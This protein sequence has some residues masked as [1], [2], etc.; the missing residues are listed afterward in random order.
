MRRCA[1]GRRWPAGRPLPPGEP[2]EAVVGV[3]AP[4]ERLGE[5]GVAFV[6]PAG[7]SPPAP[8]EL[9]EWA[10]ARLANSRCPGATTS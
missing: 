7:G 6:V 2:G 4:D 3:G 9:I 5:V 8:G 10:R 1:R